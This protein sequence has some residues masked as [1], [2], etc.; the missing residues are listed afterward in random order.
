MI[1]LISS[2]SILSGHGGMLVVHS[3]GVDGVLVG[4][5]CS[6]IER[7]FGRDKARISI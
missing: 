5:G 7:F 1:P 4:R 2:H 3:D 6:S